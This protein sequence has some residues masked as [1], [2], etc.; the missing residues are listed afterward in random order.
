MLM[1]AN[2]KPHTIEVHVIL[3]KEFL[4]VVFAFGKIK[5]AV[6]RLN[7]DSKKLYANFVYYISF[8]TMN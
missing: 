8:L 4:N 1:F 6:A 2:V 3:P 7:V 5:F